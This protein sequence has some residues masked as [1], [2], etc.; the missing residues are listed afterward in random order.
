M[1]RATAYDKLKRI[2]SEEHQGANHTDD[3][4]LGD[5]LVCL[6]TNKPMLTL[7]SDYELVQGYSLFSGLFA[8]DKKCHEAA[9]GLA[10][11]NYSIGRYEL[12]EKLLIKAYEAKRDFVYRV[13]LGYTQLQMFLVAT[14]PAVKTKMANNAIVNLDRCSKEPRVALY[15]NFA[16]ICLSLRVEEAKLQVKGLKDL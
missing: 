12:S 2:R 3:S 5:L 11:I 1:F 9:F 13:W 14:D 6:L 8:Q 15:A 7:H 4:V 10:R 16:L